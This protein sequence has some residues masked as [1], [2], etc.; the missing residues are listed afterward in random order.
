[1]AE[2]LQNFGTTTLAEDLDNSETTV[3]VTSGSVFPSSG[4]FRLNCEDEIMICTSRSSNDLTVTRGAEGT[5][6]AT[7]PNGTTIKMVLTS[8]ALAQV[9][10][11][12]GTS[13]LFE[14]ATNSGAVTID[15]ANGQTQFL[16]LTG[17][18]TVTLAGAFTDRATDLLLILKQDA[19][20]SRLVT[21]PGSVSW[22]GGAAPSLQTTASAIDV[23]NLMSV[24]D[25]TSWLGF[26]VTTRAALVNDGAGVAT[27]QSTTSTSYTDLATTGPAVTVVVNTKVKVTLSAEL[28]VGANGEAALMSVA[29]SGANTVAAADA[30]SLRVTHTST[31][32]TDHMSRVLY[33][34]GLT[35]GSTTFTAKYR[36]VVGSGAFFEDRDILVE[37][38]D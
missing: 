13:S 30:R 17:D 32:M 11:E 33:F 22:A 15:R 29:I 9:I 36:S 7:H 2:Q 35:P 10:D 21:W 38:L 3:T 8:A 16:T 1:M 12:R 19:T 20:G 24:D 37:C 14:D 6:A 34:S 18:V 27:A 5:A 23:V 4:N 25:G 26:H 28:Y 31:S